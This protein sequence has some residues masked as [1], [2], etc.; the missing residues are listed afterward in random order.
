MPLKIHFAHPVITT[1]IVQLNHFIDGDHS[2][3]YKENLAS[4]SFSEGARLSS[5]YALSMDG[6]V[7]L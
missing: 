3:V 2:P 4:A 6:R 1:D 5:T 7:S